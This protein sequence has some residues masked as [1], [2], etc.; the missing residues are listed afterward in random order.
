[1]RQKAKPSSTQACNQAL[2]QSKMRIR[3]SAIASTVEAYELLRDQPF[4]SSN[5]KAVTV[6]RTILHGCGAQRAR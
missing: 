5:K 6:V 4:T 2:H 3:M 1:M